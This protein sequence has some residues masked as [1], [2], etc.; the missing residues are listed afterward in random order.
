MQN[1]MPPREGMSLV[2]VPDASEVATKL[3]ILVIVLV[4]G[5]FCIVR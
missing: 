3:I 4:N 2:M 1:T 5:H